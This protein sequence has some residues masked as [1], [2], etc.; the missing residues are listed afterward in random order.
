L[1]DNKTLQKALEHKQILPVFIQ[2]PIFEKGSPNRR[3][4]FLWNNLKEFASDL[5]DR[6]SYLVVRKGKPVH[7]LTD[8]LSET[9]ADVIYA[10]EDYTPYDRLRSTLVGG[11]LPLKLVQGQLGL[12]PL[13]NVKKNGSPYTVFSPFLKT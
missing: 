11:A 13:A 3:Q 2:D 8:L 4:Q 6:G 12:H 9:N 10:E 1:N 5:Q 7:V